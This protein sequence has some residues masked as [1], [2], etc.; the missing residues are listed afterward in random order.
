LGLH[1][2]DQSLSFQSQCSWYLCYGGVCYFRLS[3]IL[4]V[5]LWPG[6]S[7][8]ESTFL[9][10]PLKLRGLQEIRVDAYEGTDLIF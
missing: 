5:C 1:Q 9:R 3:L 10:P 7:C 2:V 4:S 6:N 8:V